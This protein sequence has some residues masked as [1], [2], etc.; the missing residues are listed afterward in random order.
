MLQCDENE[1][2]TTQTCYVKAN[3]Y[4]N[5]RA[6]PATTCAI[7]TITQPGQTLTG[8]DD[9]GDWYEIVLENGETAFVVGYL[10]SAT[11]PNP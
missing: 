10:L 7:A 2:S 6:C 11:P 9:S 1:E 4:V 3:D 5:I 8:C